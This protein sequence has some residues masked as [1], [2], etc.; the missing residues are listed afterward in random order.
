M[1][2]TDRDND[3]DRDGDRDNDSDRDGDRDNDSDIFTVNERV[4]VTD[5]QGVFSLTQV[6][7]F[8]CPFYCSS[9]CPQ[10]DPWD[11]CGFT[12][13]ETYRLDMRRLHVTYIIIM[14]N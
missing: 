5:K 14:E 11:D 10:K 6:K 12:L 4:T 3:S 8:P 9:M 7:L 2:V 1:T 13:Y